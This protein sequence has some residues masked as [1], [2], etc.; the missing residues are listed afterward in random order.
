LFFSFSIRSVGLVSVEET[1]PLLKLNKKWQLSNHSALL[2]HHLL[3]RNSRQPQLVLQMR[4][5]TQPLECLT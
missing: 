4:R 2:P 5:L 3:C 1:L